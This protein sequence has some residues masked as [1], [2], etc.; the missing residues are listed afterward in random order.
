[1][2]WQ[3]TLATVWVVIEYA[4]KIAALGTVPEN[5]RPSSSTAWLLLIF[6]LP[7]VGLP[8]YIFLGSPRVHGRRR[9]QQ[10]EANDA[11]L[12]LTS[13]L[14]DVPEGAEPSE[15]LAT[16]LAM[17]RCLTGLPCVTGEVVGLHGDAAPTYEAMA[18]AVD[19]A[20][21]HVHVEFYIQSWDEVTDVFYSSLERAAARGVTVR[22]L[23][24][25]LGSRKYP[26]WRRL[27]RRWEAAGIQW[28][29]MMPLLPLKGR[30][31]RPD[32]RNHRKLLII[33]GE[34]A[35]IGSHNIIDP[36]YRLR[37]NI[38]AGRRWHD[39]SVEVTGEVVA[40]A[41]AV[42]TMDWFFESGEVLQQEEFL[43]AGAAISSQGG[44]Q[45]RPGWVVGSPAPQPGRPGA[46]VNAM[47]IIPSGPGYPTEPN[48]RMFISLIQNATKQVSITSPY[49]I[50]DEA[51]LSAITSAAYR[52]VDVELFVGLES[53]HLIVNHAQ[54]SYYGTLLAAGVRIYR[55]PAPTVLHA[56]YMTIDGEVAV[57]GSSNMDFR[58]FTL[59][60]EVMLLAFG[61]DLDDLL[62]E[63]DAVYREVS[64]ELTA[65]EWAKEP[66]HRRYVD[67]VF[68]LL[69]AVL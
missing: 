35:F 28:R 38:R 1:M 25:H 54:R 13:G 63:N 5:R 43:P 68:R 7:V 19:Q 21:H 6:L 36:S 30:F 50:P 31:R 11:T 2:E 24:D 59:N 64:T 27:G 41:Q 15:H 17:N 12:R 40:Q 42:F 61:G 34:R 10:E 57:I 37:S 62:R 3:T 48:L 60:Y 29:L 58:S 4:I 46:V 65:Q 44:L 47:Q 67:N 55:Y 52:G 66:W 9:E 51:L 26:G 14:P 39:L 8:L 32:L 20:R 53:D 22:L 49:F 45:R 33:D 23:V 18:R 16:V 56:K 69:S